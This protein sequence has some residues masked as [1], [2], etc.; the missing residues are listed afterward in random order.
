[1]MMLIGVISVQNKSFS[2]SV[3]GGGLFLAGKI[4]IMAGVLLSPY[5]MLLWLASGTPM[6]PPLAGNINLDFLNSHSSPA[7]LVSHISVG[8]AQFLN[9]DVMIY[10]LAAIPVISGVRRPVA[11]VATIVTP[12]FVFIMAYFAAMIPPGYFHRYAFPFLACWWMWVIFD[13]VREVAAEKE[14]K[15][16]GGLLLV[17]LPIVLIPFFISAQF[18]VNITGLREFVSSLP[19]Q[20]ANQSPLIPTASHEYFLRLQEHVPAGKRIFVMVDAPYLF[21]RR[22]NPIENVESVG[23]IS[24]P[25]GLPLDSNAQNLKKYLQDLGI[26]YVIFV[27]TDKALMYY[28]KDYWKSNPWPQFS[29]IKGYG[30]MVIS[31]VDSLAVLAMTENVIFLDDSH[32]LLSLR[33][34]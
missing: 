27:H 7:G 3:I 8:V 5:M 15:A 34:Q 21:D 6:Y 32:T 20:I 25:P 11:F 12:L 14:G 4:V 19:L 17:L 23:Q 30:K 18:S 28:K 31:L 2:F 13:T 10:G 26:E 22:R 16:S 9:P 24:P 33:K 29:F 1:M